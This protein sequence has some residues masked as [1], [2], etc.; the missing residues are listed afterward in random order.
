[1]F[2]RESAGDIDLGTSA[3]K[4]NLPLYRP[5]TIACIDVDLQPIFPVGE[6]WFVRDHP[7]SGPERVLECGLASDLTVFGDIL[8]PDPRDLRRRRSEH[9]PHVLLARALRTEIEGDKQSEDEE[10]D[11]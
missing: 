10:G 4:R 9:D 6:L 3:S 7:R 2:T 1:V 5:A 11:P 8:E